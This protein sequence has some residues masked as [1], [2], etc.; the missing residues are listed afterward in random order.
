MLK[1]TRHVPDFVVDLLF[2]S[3]SW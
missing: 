2:W 3:H 1:L